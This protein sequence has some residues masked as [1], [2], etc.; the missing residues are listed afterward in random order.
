MQVRYKIT[1]NSWYGPFLVFDRETSLTTSLPPS[2]LWEAEKGTVAEFTFRLHA[3]QGNWWFVG[4]EAQVALNQAPRE[5][6]VHALVDRFEWFPP[7]LLKEEFIPDRVHWIIQGGHMTVNFFARVVARQPDPV[8]TVL[9]ALYER[10]KSRSPDYVQGN[11]HLWYVP[12]FQV[13]GLENLKDLIPSGSIYPLSRLYRSILGH[14]IFPVRWVARRVI[15]DPPILV[16]LILG[17]NDEPVYVMSCDHPNETLYIPRH[18]T[19]LFFATH[20][21]PIDSHDP[22]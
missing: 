16:A 8:R 4:D 6:M 12:H 15:S 18:P 17:Y 2:W 7:G 21:F 13:E 19:W 10:F 20:P 3:T 1:F 9:E 22:D 14:L 11:L 5:P